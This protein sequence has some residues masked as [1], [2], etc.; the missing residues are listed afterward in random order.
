LSCTQVFQD[1][2]IKLP[3]VRSGRRYGILPPRAGPKTKKGSGKPMALRILGNFCSLADSNVSG[4]VIVLSYVNI[5]FSVVVPLNW[6]YV[7]LVIGYILIP[8]WWC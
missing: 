7:R 6:F 3:T 5:G 1:G 4:L 8:D 2:R